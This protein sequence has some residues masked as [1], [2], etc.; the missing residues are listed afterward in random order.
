MKLTNIKRFSVLLF[1]FIVITT[2]LF[3]KETP[4]AKDVKK[5]LK[6]YAGLAELKK[7]GFKISA[8]D[9]VNTGEDIYNVL[10]PYMI[11][12]GVP[13]DNTIAF[14]DKQARKTYNFK[15]HY[16]VH[17]FDEYGTKAQLQA[18]GFKDEEIFPYF[19][20]GKDVYRAG[21]FSW[22]PAKSFPE[23]DSSGMTP[24]P[25]LQE[26]KFIYFFPIVYTQSMYQ[27]YWEAASAKDFIILDF[28]LS[29]SG[30]NNLVSSFFDYLEQRNYQGQIFIIIDSSSPFGESVLSYC[31]VKWVNGKEEPRNLRIT[32]IGDNTIGYSNFS[33]E[34]KR[35]E[36]ERIIIY[37]VRTQINKYKKY[38][39]GVGQKPDIWAENSEDIYKTIEVLTDIKNFSNKIQVFNTY[40]ENILIQNNYN[41]LRPFKW[42]EVFCTEK[43]DDVFFKYF[44][45]FVELQNKWNNFF[46]NH[47]D[48]IALTMN[49]IYP[50]NSTGYTLSYDEYINLFKKL[51]HIFIPENLED[52]KKLDEYNAQLSTQIE[53]K[54]ASTFIDEK[55]T[56]YNMLKKYYIGF[57][58]MMNSGFTYNAWE[59]V[60]DYDQMTALFDKCIDD[61]HLDI[62]SKSGFH[63]QRKQTYDKDSIRSSDP[64]KTYKQITTSNTWYI[65]YTSC[66]IDWNEYADFPN[67]ANDA[68]KSKYIVLDFRSN[69]GGG[70]GE[71]ARFFENLIQQ[72]YRGTIYVAQDNWC[73]SGGEV[74]SIAS[75]YTDKLN[76]KLIGTH[77]GGMSIT[78]NCEHYDE[79]GIHFY[80]PSSSFE[81][82]MPP[83]FLG[84]G[85]GFEPDIWANKNDMK[86]ILEKEGLDLKG[87]EFN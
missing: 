47:Q 60:S 22:E 41:F 14:Y 87:I 34:W 73:Y 27:D 85:K 38:D 39:E 32:S 21:A 37:G 9:S 6:S 76:L 3:G 2:A 11:K 62:S 64:F 70:N 77:S 23:Y 55:V 36:T 8:L 57:Y 40:Y 86:A 45:Q 82:Y 35:L 50:L 33:G 4:L 46:I 81:T 19:S 24:L 79:N 1:F 72:N 20:K 51:V 25:P 84:E 58:K 43:N 16:T 48:N 31:L 10:L 83:N 63:Y 15:Q 67:K 49:N 5:V 30:N 71:Q 42:P 28:R 44:S 18:K 59:A 12:D 75:R 29:S 80:L 52:L 65:R 13:L 7:R 56:I 61:Y 26:K 17:F 68:K 54:T 74:W 53:N 69:P 66:A 78:G